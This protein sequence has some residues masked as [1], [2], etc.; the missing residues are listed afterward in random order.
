MMKNPFGSSFFC[1]EA[2]ERRNKSRWIDGD[3]DDDDDFHGIYR[4]SLRRQY[5]MSIYMPYT[6]KKIR[7]RARCKFVHALQ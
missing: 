1:L 5:I 7:A 4:R 2:E 3:H 6:H